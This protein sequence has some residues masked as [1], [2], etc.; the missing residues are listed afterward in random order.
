MAAN[1]F[2]SLLT[3]SEPLNLDYN[4]VTDFADVSQY[5][6]VRVSL[7]SDSQL[8]V[9]LEW[10]MDGET[11]N[12]VNTWDAHANSWRSEAT[13]V[14]MPYLRVRVE[15]NIPCA[16]NRLNLFVV[17]VSI[18]KAHRQPDAEKQEKQER[19]KSIKTPFFHFG[20]KKEVQS[21]RAAPASE[22]R[23]PDFIPSGALLIGGKSNKLEFIQRGL[24]G[25]IL[26]MGERG[27][28]WLDI[29]A[30]K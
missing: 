14:I 6:K 27:P 29:S 16:N 23:V 12:I 30:L 17:P 25:E 8:S 13:E 20:E 10:S 21:P 11:V 22:S 18:N 1:K 9:F 7:E 28:M 3:F 5:K 15:K 19:R 4:K 24:P 2:I 26:V